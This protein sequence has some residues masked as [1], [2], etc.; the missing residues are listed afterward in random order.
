MG[1]LVFA[2]PGTRRSVCRR[3]VRRPEL[4]PTCPPSAL[5]TLHYLIS[6][7]ISAP[8]WRR[9]NMRMCLDGARVSA[10]SM[11]NDVAGWK[12]LG[13]SALALATCT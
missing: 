5:L 2:E 13:S 3:T 7:C 11:A 4:V 1:K 10:R 8:Y 12:L 6:P 9:I